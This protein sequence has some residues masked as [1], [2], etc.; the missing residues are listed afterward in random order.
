MRPEIRFGDMQAG[1]T[2]RGNHKKTSHSENKPLYYRY[3]DG[4]ITAAPI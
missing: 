1:N 3:F 4:P 2:K